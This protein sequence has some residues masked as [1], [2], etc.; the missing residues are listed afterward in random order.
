MSITGFNEKTRIDVNIPFHIDALSDTEQFMRL[1]S[2]TLAGHTK[3]LSRY[4]YPIHFT[5]M[6]VTQDDDAT[7][8]ETYTIR[9]YKNGSV[10]QT[11]TMTS[12]TANTPTL[13]SLSA[14]FTTT[15]SDIIRVD[16]KSSNATAG[17]EVILQL[18]GYYFS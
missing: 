7:G 17:D 12:G 14:T 11:E 5:E 2:D 18:Y 16:I 1:S 8:G 13:K 10:T 15:L 3:F 6:V 4:K 9:L